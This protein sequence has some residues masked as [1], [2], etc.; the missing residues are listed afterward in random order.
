MQDI[1]IHSVSTRLRLCFY[2][3]KIGGIPTG[4]ESQPREMTARG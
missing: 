3:Q 1:I 4:A 2:Y